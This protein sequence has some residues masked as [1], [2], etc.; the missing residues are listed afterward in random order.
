MSNVAFITTRKYLKSYNILQIFQQINNKKFGGKLIVFTDSEIYSD[1][2]SWHIEYTDTKT[3]Y[4]IDFYQHGKRKLGCKHPNNQ[5]MSYV[6]DVFLNDFGLNV[7]GILSD[8]GISETY[9]PV[10]NKHKSYNNYIDDLLSW[11]KSEENKQIEKQ[12][13][14]KH[15]PKEMIHY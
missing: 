2:Q 13:Y 15:C 14:L 11:Y 7:D 6:M 3:F 8:E 9:K 5:W 12:F 1:N 4:A 10:R